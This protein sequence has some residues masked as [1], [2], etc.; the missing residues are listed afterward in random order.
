MITSKTNKKIRVGI[1]AAV[2][3][4]N[5]DRGGENMK[6]KEQ[7]KVLIQKGM[8][9]GMIFLLLLV[10]EGCQKKDTSVTDPLDSNIKQ[11][12]TQKNTD[13]K[14]ED[15]D[16]EKSDQN[17]KDESSSAED[18]VDNEEKVDDQNLE[19]VAFL[20]YE[21]ILSDETS[22][23]DEDQLKKAK[24]VLENGT[25]EKASNTVIK[26]GSFIW[27]MIP[28]DS[29]MQKTYYLVCRSEDAGKSWEY[30]Q[31]E[32]AVTAGIDD[33][34][35]KDGFIFL[36][37]G[38][39]MNWSKLE[40]F[41]ENGNKKY[42]GYDREE[43]LP[44]KYQLL[45]ER[46]CAKIKKVDTKKKQIE[47]EWYGVENQKEAF[48]TEKSSFSGKNIEFDSKV[49]DYRA[50]REQE[51]KT[52]YTFAKA[53]SEVLKEENLRKIYDQE[54][55]IG[56]VSPAYSIRIAINEIYARK[57]Y[58]FTGTAYENYFSQ[59]SWYAPVKGKIVQESE[60]NQYEKENIDLLV[61]LEKN[62][63]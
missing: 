31:E 52:G 2:Q 46:A 23:Y 51:E 53:D 33:I 20:T 47:L 29:G 25:Y 30:M 35:S 3:K 36:T 18:N 26:D 63:K 32:Y 38:S 62:Y 19:K 59:K 24:E 15:S 34:C 44:E 11:E 12:E 54:K 10:A 58:D 1:R 55:L 9:V 48:L 43:I 56:E 13:Q 42:T 50:Y 41:A 45:A 22:I 4:S 57:G 6:K 60:I 40:I 49:E 39:G 27:V 28:Q 17:K 21:E 7:K 16:T 14:N 61:K 5:L 37:S 8:T